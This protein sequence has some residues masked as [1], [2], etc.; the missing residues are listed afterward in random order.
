MIINEYI[1][2]KWGDRPQIELARELAKRRGFGEKPSAYKSLVNKW[3]NDQSEPSK[4]YLL[5]L[6]EILG[7][8]VESI[9]RGEDTFNNYDIRPTAYAAAIS[10]D[11]KI[12]ELLFGNAITDIGLDEKDEYAKSFVDYVIE[13]NNYRAFQIAINKGYNYPTKWE[14][15]ELKPNQRKVDLDLTKMIVE[16]DDLPMFK[17]AFGMLY[18]NTESS[19]A[20]YLNNQFPEEITSSLLKSHEILKWIA[21]FQP[22]TDEEWVKFNRNITSKESLLLDT[23]DNYALE[24]PSMAYG[25]SYILTRAIAEK[26]DSLELLLDYALNYMEQLNSFLGNWT[27]NFGIIQY[28]EFAYALCFKNEKWTTWAF[29]PFVGNITDISN[30]RLRQKAEKINRQFPILK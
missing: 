3:F 10:G 22:F 23:N 24:I 26:S 13:F 2:K 27:S 29:I 28:D 30:D 20:V 18:R 9:L 17:K 19:H 21:S 8:T 4:E 6:S 14:C 11:E 15:L 1:R 16:A 7:V 5:V 12:I 25:Y